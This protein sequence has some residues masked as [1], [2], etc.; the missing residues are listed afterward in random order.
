MPGEVDEWSAVRIHMLQ[1]CS[2]EAPQ[3]LK[4]RESLL[5][6]YVVFILALPSASCW[7]ADAH[8]HTCTDLLH[9]N[10]TQEFDASVQEPQQ[11][12]Q[13]D[14]LGLKNGVRKVLGLLKGQAKKLAPAHM[15]GSSKTAEL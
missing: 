5:V 3:L 10:Y 1:S 15:L 12:D 8:A 13:G 14:G 11:D 2:I 9:R 6:L 7:S 4:L